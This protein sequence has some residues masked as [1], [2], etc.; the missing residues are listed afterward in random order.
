MLL[1]ATCT[2]AGAQTK[3]LVLRDFTFYPLSNLQSEDNPLELPYQSVSP[4]ITLHIDEE[5]EIKTV[6]EFLEEFGTPLK[7]SPRPET[8]NGLRIGWMVEKNSEPV[9]NRMLSAVISHEASGK[10]LYVIFEYAASN[11]SAEK[12]ALAM[13]R[14]FR[15]NPAAVPAQTA[16]PVKPPITVPVTSPGKSDNASSLVVPEQIVADHNVYRR[17]LG[18]PDLKWS[19]VLAEYA[20]AWANELALKRNCVMQHRP[21]DTKS[22]W[23]LVYGENIFS[24]SGG[25]TFRDAVKAWGDEKKMFNTRTKQCNGGWAPCG[26][27]TQIIWRQT[28]EVGCAVARCPNGTLI[29]VCNYNPAGNIMGRPPY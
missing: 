6:Q 26:H 27:Y 23:N 12:N 21:H 4:A 10:M 13:L 28:T 9:K 17:E 19:P 5:T 14:S 3:K 24:G 16:P 18:V 22:P 20:Q 7:K 25:Y 11:L 29:M 2:A 8:V 15:L 1:A